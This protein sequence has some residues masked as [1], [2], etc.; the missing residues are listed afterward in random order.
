MRRNRAGWRRWLDWLQRLLFPA[1]VPVRQE[2]T[3]TFASTKKCLSLFV[4][5]GLLCVTAPVAMAQPATS[6]VELK[7]GE[8]IAYDE[9]KGEVTVVGK[10]AIS[11]EFSQTKD[12]SDEMLLPIS[13]ETKVTHAHGYEELK[14]GDTV[15]V[16]YRQVY[17]E[18]EDGERIILK[19][20]ATE[21]ARLRSAPTTG[22][23]TA[24]GN[25]LE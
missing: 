7:E 1:P 2:V 6:G 24:E 17:R 13:P 9:V 11:V 3:V 12:S 22:L 5:A 16:T 14:R 10:R 4:L 19:T 18:N 25:R 20:T 8:K 15:R 21:I 23:T